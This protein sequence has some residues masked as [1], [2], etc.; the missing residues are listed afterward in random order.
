MGETINFDS[1]F[2]IR[3]M[4]AIGRFTFKSSFV[5]QED[6]D[7]N[8]LSTVQ[9]DKPLATCGKEHLQ[10]GCYSWQTDFLNFISF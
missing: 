3:S 2:V 6:N 1:E 9:Y 4:G 5:H 7:G 10:Y 8:I